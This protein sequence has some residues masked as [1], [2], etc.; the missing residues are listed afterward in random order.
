MIIILNFPICWKLFKLLITKLLNHNF[1]SLI[2]ILANL[3]KILINNILLNNNIKDN[4]QQVTKYTNLVGTSETIREILNKKDKKFNEWLAGLIDGDGYFGITQKKY[5]NCEIT[6]SLEDEKALQQIKQRFGGSIKLRSNVKAVRYRLHNYKGM[7]NLINAVNGNIRNS[8]RLIQLHKVCDLLNIKPLSPIKLSY[9]NSWFIGFFDADGTITY[10]FKNNYPQ[11]TISVTNKYLNDIIYF[12]DL[13]KGNIYFDKSQ[14]GYFKWMIQSE[15]DINNLI[16]NY[17][18]YNP[19]RTTKF[20]KLMLSKQFF[21]LKR[22]KAYQKPINSV[23]FKAWLKFE[24]KWK[25]SC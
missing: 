14:N 17:I 19:S 10:S 11:L 20:N 2:L 4:N 15:Y 7:I 16:Y 24:T 21:E 3:V 1:I 5:P 23:Q 25:N 22:I 13:F 6:V 18:K 8:K 9:D 12:K